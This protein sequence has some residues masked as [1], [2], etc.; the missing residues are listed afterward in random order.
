[1]FRAH[2]WLSIF[3]PTHNFLFKLNFPI[4]W[5]RLFASLLP[6]KSVTLPFDN[7]SLLTLFVEVI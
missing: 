7:F 1:M 4:V 5:V 6:K 3:K 2:V